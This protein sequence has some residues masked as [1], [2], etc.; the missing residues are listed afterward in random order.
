MTKKEKKRICQACGGHG[1]H[2]EY[3]HWRVQCAACNGT[4]VKKLGAKR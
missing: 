1:F 2:G 4:G 3:S